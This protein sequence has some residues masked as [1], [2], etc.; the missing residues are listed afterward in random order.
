MFPICI[1][2][3]FRHIVLRWQSYV[4][5]DCVVLLCFKSGYFLVRLCTQRASRVLELSHVTSVSGGP[6]VCW[7][8]RCHQKLLLSLSCVLLAGKGSSGIPHNPIPWPTPFYI[9][10]RQVL[11]M[12]LRT[13]REGAADTGCL[14]STTLSLGTE[15]F[16]VSRFVFAYYSTVG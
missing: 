4:T 13:L 3:H 12:R 6:P 11:G 9:R 14:M 10:T 15:L 1:R 7:G 16:V 5:D 8:H 2:I